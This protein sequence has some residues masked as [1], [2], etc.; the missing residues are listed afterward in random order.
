MALTETQ[1]PDDVT[2]GV[3][4]ID[5]DTHLMEPPD[6][7]TARLS[8]SRWGDDIPHMVYDER[9]GRDRWLIGGR[10]LTSVAN[11]AVAGWPEFPPSHPPRMEDA[12][13]AAWD[14]K[15]RLAK[16][17]EYGVYASVLYPN[18]LAFV[19]W[20]FLSIPDQE[21]RLA[22]VRA[23]NDY[24]AEFSEPAPDRLVAL[25]VLPFWDVEASVTELI[26]A[27]DMGHRGVLFIGKP[28]KLGLPRLDDPHWAPVLEAAQERELSVNF[29]TALKEMTEEDFRAQ[30]SRSVSRADYAKVSS[31]GMIGLAETV[32]DLLL[33][34]VCIRYPGLKFV[35]VESGF[36]WLPY[37]LETL[38][39]Q[40]LNSGAGAANPEREAPSFYFRRQLMSTFWFEREPVSAMVEHYA[41]NVMFETDFPH[42]TSLS[43]G[44]A[45]SSDVPRVMANAS[46]AGVA[47]DVVRKVLYDNAAA[48]YHIKGR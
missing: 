25:T 38:D 46:F 2:S 7:W 35:I 3:E 29:D 42:P 30:L 19:M 11:W 8:S 9:H 41:D 4:I 43:P 45:S 37:F 16:M 26:R 44:P 33:S 17:D 20:A 14:A 18:L 5:T 47:D 13:P 22:C 1:T 21:L 36:G 28:H 24:Q 34:D 10:K 12:D 15:S 27:H 32:A 39:W 48:L 40:W 6:L 31:L 23:Y